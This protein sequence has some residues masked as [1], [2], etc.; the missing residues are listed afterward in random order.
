MLHQTIVE[1]HGLVLIRSWAVIESWTR[2]KSSQMHDYKKVDL[3]C[4]A[5]VKTHMD[6]GNLK[7]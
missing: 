5:K 4:Y 6:E 2:L 1:R 7:P 3:L